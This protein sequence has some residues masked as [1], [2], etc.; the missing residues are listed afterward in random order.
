MMGN[1]HFGFEK[2]NIENEDDEK[3]SVE[4]H[5]IMLE[6]MTGGGKCEEREEIRLSVGLTGPLGGG[7]E[8]GE[9]LLSL[10]PA[11]GL[12]TT[13]G[14]DNHEVGGED[15]DHGGNSVLDLLLRGDTRRVDVVDTRADLVGVAVRLEDIKELEVG[16]G[17]LDGDDISVKSLDRGED[18]SKV[19]VTE[20][21]V[22]LDVVLNTRGG[23]S[24]RVNGP[25]K[26]VVPVGLSEGKTLSDS[27]LVDLDSLDTGVGE[28]NDLV[29]EGKSKLLRLNLLGDISSREGPVKDGNGASKHTLH[30]LLSE[31]LSVSR[32]LNGHG[33]RSGDVRDNDR[34]SDVSGTVR[35]DP[36]ELSEDETVE[37]LAKVLDHV[38]SLGLAVDEEVKTALLLEVNDSLD[39]VLHSL[40]VLLLGD[41]T[42]AELGT[43]NS[44]L[45]G[46]GE[47]TDGGGGELGEVEVLLLG[48]TTGRE[49]RLSLEL[50][51]GDGSNS[52]TDS[53]VRGSLKLSS[54]SNVLGVL[55]EDGT[56]GTV[57]SLGKGGNFL[58]LLLGEREPA[59]LLSSELV[60]NL[61]GDGGVE[62]RRRGGD[63]DT[64]GT[65][66][67]DGL[68]GESLGSLEVVLPNV[69][70]RND[71]E[72]EVELGGLDGGNNLLEL[73]GLTVEVEVKSE[74]G[75]VLEERNGLADSAVG[76]GDGDLG[77]NGSKSLVGLLE[78]LTLGLGLVHHKDRLVELNFLN[79]SLLELR[80]ELLVDRD[81]LVEEVEGLEL[82]G[83]RVGL[84][85]EREISDRTE[86]NRSGGDAEL[87]G[88]L[89]LSKGLVVVELEL[90]LGRVVDLDNVVVGVKELAHFASND[91][92][93]LRP[94]LSSTAHSEVG[95]EGVKLLSNVSL[96][97]NTKVERVVEEVVV[98]GEL[99]GRDGVN[100]SVLDRLPSLLPDVLGGG[101]ELLSG[102][103]AG[104]VSLNGLL[105]GTVD[106]DTGVTKDSGLDH[107]GCFVDG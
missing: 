45:L 85:D 50:L 103:L 73:L 47:R 107:F 60:L 61:D 67:S 17:S 106:T 90:G 57:K 38:V 49:R 22:D 55:L 15:L 65:E 80:E 64:V 48:L 44:D 63:R 84:S 83:G 76:R 79:T 21:G 99:T 70:A 104:P 14:V 69:S 78:E 23:E 72:L 62:K 35:L 86:K 92:D 33:R 2:R 87:L 89:V 31:A 43:G 91:V 9:G 97:D 27:G 32:P 34:G 94:V 105:H 11:S 40:L 26:V 51:L 74:D 1:N 58:T 81:K 41:L 100:T 8:V 39:L 68:L 20:V 4:A 18:V 6:E 88:L 29:S 75:E 93:T 96:G 24:E 3:Q 66:L 42:L 54:G 71:T 16:L 5:A 77:G 52:V 19:R 102:D 37:L 59:Q 56:L 13:V 30:G 98:K 10:L 46:L 36:T 7:D 53:R 101:L 82:G 95:V 25:G 12:E 28:V